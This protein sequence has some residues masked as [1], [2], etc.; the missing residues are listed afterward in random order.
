MFKKYLSTSPF[1]LII[2]FN[3]IQLINPQNYFQQ[4]HILK[5]NQMNFFC[6]LFTFKMLKDYKI[7]QI[8][9]HS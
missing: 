9:F 6:Y 8:N 4:F 2:Q 7:I 5:L 1:K 3:K